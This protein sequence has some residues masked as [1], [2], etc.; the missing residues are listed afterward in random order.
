ML[1]ILFS[2]YFSKFQSSFIAS[3]LSFKKRCLSDE[4]NK[5]ILE[6][7]EMLLHTVHRVKQSSWKMQGRLFL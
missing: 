1:I 2:I 4:P 3:L 6:Q 5:N 7:L